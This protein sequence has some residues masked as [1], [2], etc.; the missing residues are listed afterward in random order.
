MPLQ[1]GHSHAHH[2]ANGESCGGPGACD[3]HSC[4]SQERSALAKQYAA[5]APVKQGRSGGLVSRHSK[6]GNP[7]CSAAVSAWKL[8]KATPETHKTLA[9]CRAEAAG[10]TSA[11]LHRA[12]GNDLKA[13]RLEHLVKSG[14]VGDSARHAKA[15]ELNAGRL[16][17][18]LEGGGTLEAVHT[19]TGEKAHAVLRGNQ[20]HLV[21]P[22]TGKTITQAPI[23]GAQH[24][25][26]VLKATPMRLLDGGKPGAGGL[27]SRLEVGGGK[28]VAATEAKQP[29]L[30]ANGGKPDYQ[31]Q[32]KRS[33]A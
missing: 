18:H 28:P 30:R 7:K 3:C 13:D 19:K 10:L 4:Q 31:A 6:T 11:K 24:L 16:A 32:F 1:S 33:L 9:A 25:R 23:A 12:A 5:S 27:A 26:D 21:N 8:G 29:A 14:K 17:S 20:L 15:R 22:T 2:H